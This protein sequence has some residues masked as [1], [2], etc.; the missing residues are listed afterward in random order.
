MVIDSETFID[1]V[2]NIGSGVI[3]HSPEGRCLFLNKT[4]RLLLNLS[5]YDDATFDIYKNLKP[6]PPLPYPIDPVTEVIKKLK[7]FQGKFTYDINDIHRLFDVK[8]FPVI[9][10]DTLIY[11]VV[12]IT[13]LS[14]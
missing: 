13:D 10:S 4:A 3:M 14:D 12:N 1:V 11:V 7:S 6:C 9:R 5:D 2:E 8:F